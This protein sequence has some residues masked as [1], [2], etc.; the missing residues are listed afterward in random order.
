VEVSH[1]PEAD[2]LDITLSR[3]VGV[4]DRGNV[5]CLLTGCLEDVHFTVRVLRILM[6]LLC[7]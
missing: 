2:A 6:L 1:G 3:R 5:Y 7:S 4:V